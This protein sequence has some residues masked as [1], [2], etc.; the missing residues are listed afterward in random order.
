MLYIYGTVYN[1]ANRI[2]QS[3]SSINKINMKKKFF[4]TDNFSTDGTYS[5]LMENKEFPLTVMQEKCT[6][7]KGRNIAMEAASKNANDED[8]FMFI[9]L[10]E[11]YNDGYIKLI[12]Y[13]ISHAN[14]NTVFTNGHLCRHS[15]NKQ[16]PWMDLTASED[17]EREARIVSAGYKLKEILNIN[18]FKDNE[19]VTYDREKRY[20]AGLLLYKRRIRSYQD[21]LRGAGCNNMRNFLFYIKNAKVRKKFYLFY[22]LIFLDV[23]MFKTIYN[24]SKDTNIEFLRR[25]VQKENFQPE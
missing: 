24:Y 19:T 10:D 1:S 17:V 14:S 25:N 7:G 13:E 2:I 9:D 11:I 8:I 3:I 23:I 21:Y 4:I 12:E 6:R 5:L 22:F 18:D 20:A 16:F 15:I